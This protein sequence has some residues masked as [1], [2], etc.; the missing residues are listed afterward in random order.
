MIRCVHQD[1]RGL[2]TVLNVMTRWAPGP[3]PQSQKKRSGRGRVGP[4]K[5][6]L[7][8]GVFIS[9]LVALFVALPLANAPAR[10]AEPTVPRTEPAI[11]VGNGPLDVAISSDGTT[12]Y[13]VNNGGDSVSVLNLSTWAVTG[14]I[15]V[16]D[17]PTSIAIDPTGT[18]AYVTNYAGDS[19][20]RI[21]LATN[22]A[23]TVQTGLLGARSV[24]FAQPVG[25]TDPK[26]AYVANQDAGTI[27]VIN[28]NDNSVVRTIVTPVFASPSG[29]VNIV[30]NAAGTRLYAAHVG[31]ATS[32]S[33]SVTIIDLTADPPVV[34]T[35]LPMGDGAQTF[36]LALSGDETQLY[37]SR[38]SGVGGTGS[39]TVAVVSLAGTPAISQTITGF[40]APNIVTLN[41]SG[42]HYFI[43][44][45]GTTPGK[46]MV[47]DPA[48][49]LIV[50]TLTVGNSP[51]GI[52][53]TPNGLRAL[54]V[55][56]GS[57]SV[58]VIS[59]YQER[60]LSFATT[61]YSL[62]YGATQT[63][64]ATPSAGA[65]TGTITYSAGS[66]TACSVDSASGLVTMTAATGTCDISAT[67]TEG[68]TTTSN[69]YAAAST[70]TSVTITP[71]AAP[72]TIRANNQSVSVGD[73]ITP[74]YT[75]T[76]GG[77]ISP[78]NLS[79]VVY[80]YAGTG[81]TTYGPSTTTPT[82]VGT[83]SVTPSA[84]TFSAGDAANYSFTYTPGSLTITETPAP[85]PANNSSPPVPRVS[86]AWDNHPLAS[87]GVD[88][89]FSVALTVGLLI[90]GVALTVLARGLSNWTSRLA[91]SRSTSGGD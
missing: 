54:V 22:V 86:P 19:L 44:D 27:S 33:S 63:V 51:F 35:S 49:N 24:V 12:A 56:F 68:G 47:L 59:Y 10:A 50:S 1:L 52:A 67:I 37:V 28:T 66:S 14:P 81:S 73:S 69:S 15:S 30:I 62:A 26:R 71:S 79:G 31:S 80:T 32:N 91:Q 20:S 74:G 87:T 3:D 75:L 8:A 58:S 48:T 77:L 45:S 42:T 39:G 84:A 85:P 23:T 21:T 9:A 57:N 40:S 7:K 55:N 38:R 13:I 46:L 17:E 72:L 89:S 43:T 88:T 53:F 18:F 65:G 41:P 76:S 4:G 61:S 29:P 6:G 36:D 16:G 5:S 82:E 78:D 2:M 25:G 64:V 11:T 70:A 34:V 83:Y 90:G 60:N